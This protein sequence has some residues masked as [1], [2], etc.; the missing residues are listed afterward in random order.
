[1]R[2]RKTAEGIVLDL[3]VKPN[4]KEFKIETEDDELIMSCRESPVKGRVNREVMKELSRLFKRR[5]EI[6]SGFSSRQKRV[7][8]RDIEVNEV[9]QILDA[10]A[11]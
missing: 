3:Y 8:I 10:T 2:P 9:R 11:L 6:I 5:V 4:S 7:L 1:M